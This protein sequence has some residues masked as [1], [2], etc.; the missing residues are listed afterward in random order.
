MAVAASA[1]A[2]GCL[3]F[4]ARFENAVQSTTRMAFARPF[5]MRSAQRLLER[6]GHGALDNHPRRSNRPE[7]VVSY[8]LRLGTRYLRTNSV[9]SSECCPVDARSVM[10]EPSRSVKSH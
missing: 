7:A 9:T 10:T 2:R 6:H 1:A 5:G 3:A 8:R 4:H